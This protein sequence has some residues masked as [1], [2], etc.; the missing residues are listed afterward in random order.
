MNIQ[1]DA[2]E[3]KGRQVDEIVRDRS[4][5]QFII[6]RKYIHRVEGLKRSTCNAV[7][8]E[9]HKVMYTRFRGEFEREEWN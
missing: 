2:G 6:D 3:R 5:Y 7:R 9:G 1:T 4:I 8:Y